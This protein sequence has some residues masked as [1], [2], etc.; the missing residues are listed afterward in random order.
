M[1]SARREEGWGAVVVSVVWEREK[2]RMSAVDPKWLGL[3][4]KSLIVPHRDL[5][6]EGARCVQ[7]QST[8]W[9]KQRKVHAGW[10]LGA[11]WWPD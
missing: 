1:H 4:A 8:H 10:I 6:Q 3:G 5:G 11:P 7:K 9:Q 2:V